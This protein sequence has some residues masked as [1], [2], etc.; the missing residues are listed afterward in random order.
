MADNDDI[1]GDFTGVDDLDFSLTVVYGRR[2]LAE[3]IARRWLQPEG[4]LVYAPDYGQ[5]LA[6]Y[7]LADADP[8]LAGKLEQEALKDERVEAVE[9]RVALVAGELSIVGRLQDAQGP[10][11]LTVAYD[12]LKAALSLGEER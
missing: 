7:L 1:G 9:V 6:D 2:A 8:A 4:T 11:D 5:G 10:F 12:G 3:A